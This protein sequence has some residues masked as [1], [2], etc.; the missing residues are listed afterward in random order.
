MYIIANFYKKLFIFSF[1][2]IQ[3]RYCIQKYNSFPSSY[4]I[5]SPNHH[6]SLVFSP[7]STR[8]VQILYLLQSKYIQE[9][10]WFLY[11][12]LMSLL[13]TSSSLPSLAEIFESRTY[14]G[15][16]LVSNKNNYFHIIPTPTFISGLQVPIRHHCEPNLV[17]LHSQRWSTIY[18]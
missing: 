2:I 7:Y 14:D 4:S 13:W 11:I 16:Y 10:S 18:V 5:A 1:H 9:S 8:K 15:V 6:R 17:C 3:C 12:S